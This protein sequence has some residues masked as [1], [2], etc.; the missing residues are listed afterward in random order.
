MENYL[1][2]EIRP[3]AREPIIRK[4]G[5]GSLICTFLTGGVNEP[6]NE[7]YVAV[8]R[9]FDD[10]VTWSEPEELFNNEKLGVW[11]TEIFNEGEYPLMA[12]HTYN[13]FS[14]YKELQTYFSVSTDNGKN[15][16]EPQSFKGDINGCSLRQGIVLSN[17]DIMFPLY[18]QEEDFSFS[19]GAGILKKGEQ[20]WHRF[21][22][23]QNSEFSFWEPNAIEVEN[24][25]IIMY[26]RNNTGVLY[27][28]ESFDYGRTWSEPIP[29]NIV[30]SDTKVTVLKIKDDIIMINN[31]VASGRTHLEISK[32]RDGINFT[33]VCFLLEREE[34][35]FYP[36]AFA[37][38]ESKMLYVAYENTIKHYLAKISYEEL[39]L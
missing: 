9:S 29:S 10:G 4:M 35:F 22:Y 24:G 38:D 21:G 11:V 39:G 6:E 7:N 13:K 36:H 33:H 18:W 5:D 17:G 8:S 2:A 1:I 28:S 15:W 19:S 16:S 27:I 34:K 12:V 25:H 20:E 26:L 31:A 3:F 23:L 30:H 32:S 14:H 37:D